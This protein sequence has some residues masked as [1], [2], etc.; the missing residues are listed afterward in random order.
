M[1]E[2]NTLMTRQ[3]RKHSM[4]ERDVATGTSVIWLFISKPRYKQVMVITMPN[5]TALMIPT[6]ISVSVRALEI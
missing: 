5:R 3:Y 1:M 6:V 2:I 4:E